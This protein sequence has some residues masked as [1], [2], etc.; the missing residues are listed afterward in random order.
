MP[1]R[2]RGR[3]RGRPAAS[4]RA[5]GEPQ[6]R[7]KPA[8]NAT[9]T[10]TGAP[11]ARVSR[12]RSAPLLT[13]APGS[14]E[15]RTEAPAPPVLLGREGSSGAPD[16]RARSASY[17]SML[18]GSGI[19]AVTSKSSEL[20][21]RLATA[22]NTRSRERCGS[23]GARPPSHKDSLDSGLS[24]AV[25]QALPCWRMTGTTASGDHSVVD[26]LGPPLT[27]AATK[28]GR[29]QRIINLRLGSSTMSLNGV[30]GSGNTSD[31][32]GAWDKQCVMHPEGA[33]RL[34]WDTVGALV[35]FFDLIVL[36]LQFFDVMWLDDI[37]AVMDWLTAIFWTVDMFLS[38]ITGVYINGILRMQRRQIMCRYATTWMP[39]DL[40][41]VGIEW[42]TLRSDDDDNAASMAGVV[43]GFKFLR[44][45]RFLRLVKVRVIIRNLERR[46]NSEALLLSLK[47][48]R[49]IASVMVLN[50]V[51]GCIW[52]ALGNSSDDGW[53][54]EYV[55]GRSVL[56]RYM[57][58]IHWSISQ[59]HGAME[60]APQ[61]DNERT[62]A[63]VVVIFALIVFS[64]FLSSMTNAMLQLQQVHEA[65]T[66]L[67][68]QLLQF[69]QE[70]RVSGMLASRVKKFV[71]LR[72]GSPFVRECDVKL[73]EIMPANLLMDIHE[74]VYAAV[75]S[76]HR[77]FSDMYTVFPGTVRQLSHEAMLEKVEQPGNI[78]FSTGDAC[79]RMLFVEQGKLS[80][81]HGARNAGMLRSNPTRAFRR[82][83]LSGTA[84]H[85]VTSG[86]RKLRSGVAEVASDSGEELI[87]KARWM[88]EAAIWTT[89][90]N[91]GELTSSG[92]T[93]SLP[94]A[95]LSSSASSASTGRRTTPARS[96]R[97]T[98]WSSS[99]RRKRHPTS[100]RAALELQRGHLR[101]AAPAHPESHMLSFRGA[102]LQDCMFLPPPLFPAPFS[103]SASSSVCP[104]L[105]LPSVAAL[106]LASVHQSTSC[107]PA[108]ATSAK[109][110]DAPI[111]LEESAHTTERSV[112]DRL[113]AHDAAFSARA[114]M[115]T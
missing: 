65:P 75:V 92:H 30:R 62:F 7:A 80:Y 69:L 99:T 90:E 109:A 104:A 58:S 35:C 4:T 25:Y 12:A 3:A 19:V 97:A 59:F 112:P 94:S 34:L 71:D 5:R 64:W 100:G 17:A 37:S 74:E 38:C 28:Q 55:E 1:G 63:V 13:G 15:P 113:C 101:C 60:V 91:C 77:L 23:S 79:G 10:P 18:G 66:K 49:H 52:Y 54:A 107:P 11:A 9:P 16:A 27:R 93:S 45:F 33:A 57:T 36:P 6:S 82:S 115:R 114:P 95:L 31:S 73:L 68:R 21:T 47:V 14:A 41:V 84:Q 24:S 29:L 2:V 32:D 44:F 110:P 53:V 51:L 86:W 42:G 20:E 50:H 85:S 40:L 26:V 76:V 61:T 39:L 81:M 96:T 78:I 43:R 48:L 56:Y 103:A 108:S 67:N 46:F 87:G 70:R 102:S 83:I 106:S 105:P 8:E 111:R 88:S 89:W 72:S 22:R 98:S